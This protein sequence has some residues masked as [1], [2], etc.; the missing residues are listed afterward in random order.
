MVV[1]QAALFGALFGLD[2]TILAGSTGSPA[3]LIACQNPLFRMIDKNG[4]GALAMSE[5]LESAKD[6]GCWMW[7]NGVRVA[8][9]GGPLRKLLD[10]LVVD[11]WVIAAVHSV[12]LRILDGVRSDVG[13]VYRLVNGGAA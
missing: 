8:A 13:R 11:D 2:G 3:V 6:A 1:L 12:W 9:A 7:D 5:L 10:R 4:D